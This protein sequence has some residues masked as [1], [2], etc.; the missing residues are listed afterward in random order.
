MFLKRLVSKKKKRF[1]D[2]A[3]DLD[4][5][6][7]TDEIIAMGFPAAG[8]EGIYRNSMADVQKFFKERHDGH[9]LV[10]NLCSERSYDAAKFNGAVR[11]FPFDDHCP[12]PI[13]LMDEFCAEAEKWLAADEENVVAV[14]CVRV[15]RR[16]WG[17]LF[18]GFFFFCFFLLCLAHT[19][20]C[21]WGFFIWFFF[22]F[23]VF[24]FVL[25]FVVQH[26]TAARPARAGPGA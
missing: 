7:I 1:K 2:E 16:F 13:S 11:C 18:W 4:L 6:Y 24:F 12:P 15:G 22:L 23:C 26:A 20:T 9:V 10:V 14:Q 3:F 17:L 5:T 25:C 8:R 21:L 19:L